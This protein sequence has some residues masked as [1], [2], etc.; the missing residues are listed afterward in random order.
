[1]YTLC[2]VKKNGEVKITLESALRSL[3]KLEAF[4]RL[5]KTDKAVIF[6]DGIVDMI[7][8]LDK[9][10]VPVDVTGNYDVALA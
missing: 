1:M 6:K 10:G 5:G 4:N 9:S 8:E 3:L 2:I 7:L